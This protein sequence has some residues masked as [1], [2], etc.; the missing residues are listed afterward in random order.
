[1]ILIENKKHLNEKLF[2]KCFLDFFFNA[3]K[4]KFIKF[5][6]FFKMAPSILLLC[7]FDRSNQDIFII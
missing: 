3:E 7:K 2:V 6:H 1:V 4:N 5:I